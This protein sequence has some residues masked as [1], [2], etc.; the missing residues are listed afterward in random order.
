L[1]TFSFKLAQ[2]EDSADLFAWRNDAL[3]RAMSLDPEPIARE[4]HEH[5][6]TQTLQDPSRTLYV[7]YRGQARVGMCRFDRTEANGSA[8][9]SI[10]LNPAFRGQKLA[11]PLLQQAMDLFCQTHAGPLEATVRRD[12]PASV[13]VFT[14]CGFELRR[15]EGELLHFVHTP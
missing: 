9:V 11:R 2:A 7:A 10:N 6:L 1:N 13:Q 15:A 3:T 12:N 8:L 14:Q 5:W 4:A